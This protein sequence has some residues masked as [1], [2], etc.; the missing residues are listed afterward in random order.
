MSMQS[1]AAAILRALGQGGPLPEVPF[2]GEAPAP[3]SPE[4]TIERYEKALD[5]HH[6]YLLSVPAAKLTEAQKKELWRASV[7]ALGLTAS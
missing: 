1:D 6:S 4:A 7:K 3:G 5:A 2:P